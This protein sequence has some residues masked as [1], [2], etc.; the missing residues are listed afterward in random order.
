MEEVLEKEKII[1]NTPKKRRIMKL[2]IWRIFA[3]LLF[4]A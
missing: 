3:Y 4:I 1:E 2:T